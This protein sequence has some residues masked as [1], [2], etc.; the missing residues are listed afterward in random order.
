MDTPEPSRNLPFGLPAIA[1]ILAFVAVPICF[2]TW[3][4]AESASRNQCLREFQDRGAVALMGS[5][6]EAWSSDWPFRN[7]QRYTN[8]ELIDGLFNDDDVRRLR[9]A[10]PGASILHIDPVTA[11]GYRSGGF[12]LL[13]P[14]VKLPED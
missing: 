14:P 9:H 8:I 5:G 11:S 2:A 4:W 12:Y 7:V 3:K 1:A 13:G 6:I 10:F